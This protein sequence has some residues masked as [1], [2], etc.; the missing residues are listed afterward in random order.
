MDY[1]LHDYDTHR[2]KSSI[3]SSD[4][5]NCAKLQLSVL[6]TENISAYNHKKTYTKNPNKL[7]EELIKCLIG[8]FLEF[9]QPLLDGEEVLPKHISCMNS[10]SFISKTTF[11]CTTQPLFY[12]NNGSNL[13]PYAILLDFDGGIRDIGPYKNFTQITRNTLDH[14]RISECTTEVAKLRYVLDV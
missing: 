5:I 11:N 14:T 12:N 1:K 4:D 9:N 10:K 6:G 3:G 13:D 7:S 8:I 2:R